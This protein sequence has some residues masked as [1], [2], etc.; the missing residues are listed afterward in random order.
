MGRHSIEKW[1]EIWRRKGRGELPLYFLFRNTFVLW[2]LDW[3]RDSHFCYLF[4]QLENY[5]WGLNITVFYEILLLV[6]S[7]F[8]SYHVSKW[9]EVKSI[10]ISSS[11]I[12]LTLLLINNIME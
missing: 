10:M 7:V 4:F 9:M 6:Y 8:Y 3:K 2:H 12:W 11:S 5:F 1:L